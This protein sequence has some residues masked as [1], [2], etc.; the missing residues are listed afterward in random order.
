[1]IFSFA[2]IYPD[3]LYTKQKINQAI[4][5]DQTLPPSRREEDRT[6]E[7]DREDI[8]NP[9]SPPASHILILSPNPLLT[10]TQ[11]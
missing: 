10:V 9:P 1:M 4:D 2:G 8:F 11:R 6:E 3:I 5:F 7:D